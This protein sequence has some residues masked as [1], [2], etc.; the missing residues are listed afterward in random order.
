MRDGMASRWADEASAIIDVA[1][2][3]NTEHRS[4]IAWGFRSEGGHKPQVHGTHGAAPTRLS[5]KKRLV[6]GVRPGIG[7]PQASRTLTPQAE[8]PW[9]VLAS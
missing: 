1:N 6:R 3:G 7:H 9:I 8:T 5:D 4:V 2:T